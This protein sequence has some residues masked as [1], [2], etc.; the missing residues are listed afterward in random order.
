MGAGADEILDLVGQGIP[1]S[2]RR[3]RRARSRPT[4]C[5]RAHIQRGARAS[6]RPRPWARRRAG[7]S[8][9]P[10]SCRRARR[11]AASS[12]CARPTTRPA[13]RTRPTLWSAS[14]RPPRPWRQS[15]PS[16]VV[17]EAYFEFTGRTVIPW[18]DAVSEP[19]RGAHGLQGLRPAR[20]PRRLGGRQHGPSSPV[21]SASARRAASPRSRPHLAARALCAGRTRRCARVAALARRAR[22]ARS[23][24]SRQS[25]GHPYPSVTN[26]LLVRIGDHERPSGGPWAA[27]PG[28]VPRTF[29]PDSPL[30]GHLRLTVRSRAENERLL[31]SIATLTG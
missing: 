1:A 20:H 6:P 16:I 12:G 25:A 3:G 17:D 15:R 19:A 21:S 11:G 2:G 18:R 24:G 27:A 5:T 13:H 26:F 9:W 31:A 7:P 14:S 8:T 30:G 10:A 22:V 29:A 28:L 23:P 4:A